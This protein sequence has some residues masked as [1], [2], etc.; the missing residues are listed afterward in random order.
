MSWF[1]LR[2][3]RTKTPHHLSESRPPARLQDIQAKEN[4]HDDYHYRL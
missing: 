2:P 4:D 3:D 1:R